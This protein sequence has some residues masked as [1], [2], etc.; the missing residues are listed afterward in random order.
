MAVV[1]VSEQFYARS[2]SSTRK[3]ISPL[4]EILLEKQAERQ[5][6]VVC[7]D[8]A[9]GPA[10]AETATG[11]PVYGDT[12]GGLELLSKKA[13]PIDDDPLI[14]NVKCS[15]GTISDSSDTSESPLLAPAIQTYGFSVSSEPVYKDANGNPIT[16]SAGERYDPTVQIDVYDPIITHTQNL[17]TFDG[18]LASYLVGGV[19]LDAWYGNAPRTLRINNISATQEVWNGVSPALKYWKVTLEVQIRFDTWDVNILDQGYTERVRRGSSGDYYFK[20]ILDKDGKPKNSP[21]L[22]DGSGRELR[23][24]VY[25]NETGI[26][27]INGSDPV[28]RKTR[29]H[30]EVAFSLLGI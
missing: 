3:G 18:G 6:V 4:G 22:L 11:I 27:I 2:F 30:R 26:K 7:N 15:Y 13:D 20:L 28:F 19:N 23:P 9:D 17:A 29:I 25:D 1:S 24:T 10:A 8:F 12:Y 5:Y 16:N 14:F 21:T